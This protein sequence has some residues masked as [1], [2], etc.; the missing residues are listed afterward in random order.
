[1]R[2]LIGLAGGLALTIL[3]ST[4]AD[5]AP[6]SLDNYKGPDAGW[7]MFS[8]TTSPVSARA[9]LYYKRLD[10]EGE[11][12]TRADPWG[13]AGAFIGPLAPK[14]DIPTSKIPPAGPLPEKMAAQGFQL[15]NA[16]PYRG[17]IA[18]E[19]LPPGRYEIYWI[20]LTN[21]VGYQDFK[22]LAIPF[23]IKPGKTTYIGDFRTV[24]V[25]AKAN[26]GF[27]IWQGWY[28]ELSDQSARDLAGYR[29]KHPELGEI[30]VSVPSLSEAG[31]DSMQPTVVN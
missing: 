18:T 16:I 20:H 19:R 28:I 10:A 5:A 23:E 27:K 2:G 17:D 26:I 25:K 12:N 11:A 3:S 22:S 1:M 14:P 21:D 6:P 4:A 7:L 9:T 24:T 29:A 13:L 15:F 30:E 31:R 8:A